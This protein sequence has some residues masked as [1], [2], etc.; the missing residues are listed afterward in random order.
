[1]LCRLRVLCAL[2]GAQYNYILAAMT[3][4]GS[5]QRTPNP[6]LNVLRISSAPGTT[7]Y[8]VPSRHHH[9]RNPKQRTR[10]PE[11]GRPLGWGLVSGRGIG[12]SAGGGK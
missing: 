7:I 12:G 4:A 3:P 8:S 2:C 10:H 11:P 5:T 6:Q 9:K 1:M